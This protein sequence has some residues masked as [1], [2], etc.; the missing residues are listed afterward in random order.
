MA[1]PTFFLGEL[2]LID[3]FNVVT[4][5]LEDQ[6]ILGILHCTACPMERVAGAVEKG[7]EMSCLGY[8]FGS[9]RGLK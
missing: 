4:G 3:T 5:E 8:H 1:F 2:L 7:I 9:P 6:W